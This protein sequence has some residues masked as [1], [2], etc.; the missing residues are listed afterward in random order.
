MRRH[1]ILA[2]AIASL[3]SPALAVT[4]T[5][6]ASADIDWSTL[7]WQLFDLDAGDG[8]TPELNF[9]GQYTTV[10][11]GTNWPMV[12]SDFVNDW[13][14]P[15]SVSGADGAASANEHSISA[16]LFAS[17]TNFFASAGRHGDFELTANTLVVFSVQ[18]FAAVDTGLSDTYANATLQTYDYSGTGMVSSYSGSYI[19]MDGFSGGSASGLLSAPFVNLSASS[20]LANLSGYVTVQGPFVPDVSPVP[21]PSAAAML[22]AGLGIAGWMARRRTTLHPD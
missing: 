1:L 14:T 18:G 17:S 19:W 12:D 10:D 4:P 13:T 6:V 7:T 21:E 5:P 15:I 16:D 2:A 11:A 8:I 9:L 22:L 3:G 20:V